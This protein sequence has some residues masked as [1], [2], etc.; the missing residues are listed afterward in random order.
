VFVHKFLI[1]IV[2][3]VTATL[4]MAQSDPAL[5]AKAKLEAIRADAQGALNQNASL[6]R[7]SKLPT[8]ATDAYNRIISNANSALLDVE[9]FIVRPQP[10]QVFYYVRTDGSNSNTG[11][12]NSSG[13]AWLTINYAV[14]NVPAGGT[15]RV[16]A[17]TYAEIASLGVSGTLSNPVTIVADGVVTTCG[18]TAASKDY[19]RVIGFVFDSDAS[20]CTP[21]SQ[22]VTITGI[23][24][25]LE[26]WNNT[27]QDTDNN[28][29]MVN[30]DERCHACIVF[31]GSFSNI[32]IRSAS[33]WNALTMT[34][35]DDYIGYVAF[36][37]ICYLAAGPSGNRQRFINLKISNLVEEGGSHPDGIYPQGAN[38]FGFSNNLVEAMYLLGTPTG[39]NQ[40]TMHLQNQSATDWED[41]VWRFSVAY[42][43]GGGFYSVYDDTSEI[44]RLHFYNN[45]IV[46]CSQAIDDPAYDSCGNFS[47][48]LGTSVIGSV[49]N[50]I[51][52]N[53]WADSAT[54]ASP[55]NESFSPVITKNY[56]LAYSSLGTI[57]FYAHWTGQANEISNTN[58]LFTNAA[59]DWTLQSGSPAR[60]AGGPVTTASGS[61]SSSTTLTVAS[62]T[63]GKFIGDNSGN[64]SQYG[65]A[66]V[67]GDII[68]VDAATVQVASVSGDVLTLASAIS[69]D[70]ADP[71]YFGS[72]S[73]IDMGAY[74]YKA[75]GYTLSATYAIA[76]GTATITPNDA[77][78]VRFVVCYSASVPYAVD[79]SSPYTCAVPSGN[80]EARAYP[81]YASSTLWA[82]A[83]P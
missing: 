65:G 79:N 35:T 14:D 21:D 48:Q 61:G 18:M 22:L 20:G 24:T 32:R 31:G 34:G 25:G 30:A 26:F 29:F 56:N 59:S 69:W 70:N 82:V 66:L 2:C 54:N 39:P 1:A 19:I 57:T 55:W 68:T 42:N 78:L 40:K 49:F 63:G 62:G 28:G 60:G 43:Q 10:A 8:W 16:Q 64:L 45:T 51:H 53:A 72:S 67:P 71:I 76:G 5:A 73:T 33:C 36:D 11:L 38:A 52:Y 58:P 77:S 15:V 46:K 75:G 50:S 9:Q 3:V 41:N 23:N 74:P 27:F 12:G 7:K 44:N 81:R 13:E 6:P 4:A 80:F 83:T 47:S 37:N 17:G